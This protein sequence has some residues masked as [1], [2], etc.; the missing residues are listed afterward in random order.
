MLRKPVWK[1]SLFYREMTLGRFNTLAPAVIVL[2]MAVV[3]CGVY[4]VWLMNSISAEI[5]EV[6]VASGMK[7]RLSGAHM[8]LSL[9]KTGFCV[10][11][12]IWRVCSSH[13]SWAAA[14]WGRS[15]CP[16]IQ[17]CWI[18]LEF[19]SFLN[20]QDLYTAKNNIPT[21]CFR[22]FYSKNI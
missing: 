11:G 2:L 7:L 10:H 17:T 12:L 16:Q 19:S 6:C 18:L 21:Q 20:F 15:L 9:I 8:F 5:L 14:V 22:L 4:C 13:S 3:L 1:H